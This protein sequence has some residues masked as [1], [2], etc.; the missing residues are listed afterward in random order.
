MPIET[1][2]RAAGRRVAPQRR[3]AAGDLL[4]ASRPLSW[5]NTAFPFAAAYLLTTRDVDLALVIGTIFFLVPYNL[6]MYGVNDVFDY[7]SDAANPRKG[8]VEGALLVPGRHRL[9]IIA[10]IAACLPFVVAL[11]A[12]GDPASWGV[13]AVSLFAVAA[14]SVPGLRF[15]EIPFLDSVTSSVHFVSP[16]VYGLV[17]AGAAFTPQL[18]ALLLAFL[19]WGMAS[20]AFGAV[21]DVV[22]DREGGIASIATVL[23]ARRTVRFAI[24][25]W[26]VAGMLM[27]ATAWPGPLAGLL[28]TPYIAVAAPFASLADAD[29]GRANAGWKRFLGINYVV[30]FLVTMLLLWYAALTAGAV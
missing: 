30:G 10:A 25:A 27:L 7:A 28:V 15:K 18:L 8:G 17:L 14:Y 2:R 9:T 4:M 24:G 22:P 21:Q 26:A 5:V 13:L 29:S 6:A 23:G 3:S 19:A 11:V 12:L 20:H 16:A 1:R